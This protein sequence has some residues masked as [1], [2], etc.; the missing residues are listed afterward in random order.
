MGNLNCYIL[1]TET[2]RKLK[3]GKVSL[4]ICQNCMREN[5]ANF[6]RPERPFNWLQGE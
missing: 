5:R 4:Q 3:F 6:F 2:R 1:V